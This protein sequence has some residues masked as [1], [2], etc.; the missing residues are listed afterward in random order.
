MKPPGDDQCRGSNMTTAFGDEPSHGFWSS[1][2]CLGKLGRSVF[3]TMRHTPRDWRGAERPFLTVYLDQLLESKMSKSDREELNRAY[4]GFLQSKGL[5]A[6]KALIKEHG[7][8]KLA[9]VPEAMRSTLIAAF[10]AKQ[11]KKPDMIMTDDIDG[12]DADHGYTGDDVD[13]DVEDVTPEQQEEA[14]RIMKKT[15]SGHRPF[16]PGAAQALYA[17]S[18]ARWNRKTAGRNEVTQRKVLDC[19]ASGQFLAALAGNW[20]THF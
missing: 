15:Q 1:P 7:G 17:K 14:R 13:D 8:D 2:P 20:P 9:D 19:I 18:Y 4:I 11:P 12:D 16:T 5:A 3:V 6:A 10:K